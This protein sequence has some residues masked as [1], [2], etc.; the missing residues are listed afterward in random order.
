MAKTKFMSISSRQKLGTFTLS[1]VLL[2]NGTVVNQISKSK[3][4]GVIIDENFTWNDHI[5]KLAKKIAS[6]IAAL[7]RVRQFVPCRP[8]YVF[9][10][11]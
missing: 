10:M 9:T 8:F 2:I 4:L 1:P 5:D 11:P 3:S 7:K 6:G